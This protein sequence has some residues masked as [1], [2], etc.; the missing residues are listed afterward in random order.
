MAILDTGI[1]FAIAGVVTA[2]KSMA[3]WTVKQEDKKM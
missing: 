2:A 1:M 3:Q